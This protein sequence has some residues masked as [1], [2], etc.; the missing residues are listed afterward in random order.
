MKQVNTCQKSTIFD[1]RRLLIGR[2]K[3]YNN[4][5]YYKSLFLANTFICS[6]FVSL[7]VEKISL[8]NVATVFFLFVCMFIKN[9]SSIILLSLTGSNKFLS[10]YNWIIPHVSVMSLWRWSSNKIIFISLFLFFFIFW[11]Q[12]GDEKNF[13][14]CLLSCLKIFLLFSYKIQRKKLKKQ[15]WFLRLF[16]WI[17]LN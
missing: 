11:T 4:P 3:S 14:Q 2:C 15:D 10:N 12:T 5:N 17:F 7:F 6:S 1:K 8:N 9:S 13:W 16:Y